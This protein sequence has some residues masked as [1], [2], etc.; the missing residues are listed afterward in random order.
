MKA[1]PRAR[2]GVALALWACLAGPGPAQSPEPDP[3]LF[4]YDL[5][6]PLDLRGVIVRELDAGVVLHDVSFASPRG[7]RVHAYMVVPSGT[8]PF[9]VIVFGPWGLGNRTEFIPEAH[10]YGRLGVASMIVDWPW[11]RPPPDRRDQG[12]LDKPEMDRDV[13]AQAVIDLRRALDVMVA[14]PDVDPARVAYVGHSYGAQFG[15]ILTAIDRRVKAAALLTGVPDN[16]AFLVDSQDA[17]AVAYRK[18]WSQEQIARYIEVNR[19]VDAIQWIGRVAPTP[20]LMQFAEFERSFDRSAMERFAAAAGEPKTVLWYPTG[21]ELNDV[22]AAVDRA[23]WVTSR[24][25]LDVSRTR[26]VELLVGAPP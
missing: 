24:L 13:F 11:T 9:P 21:H 1:S 16:A 19:P 23:A 4:A 18:R 15:A 3:A 8:G 12:P 7:G 2:A 6:A 25:R 17:D 26:L 22:R 5:S 14:R 10:L 20:L